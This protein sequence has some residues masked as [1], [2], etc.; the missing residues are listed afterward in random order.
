[1]KDLLVSI[2]VITYNQEQYIAETI[3]NIIAQKTSFPIEIIIGDD[4]STDHTR[5]ICIAY[6]E[7]YPDIIRLRLPKKNMGSMLNWLAN[8]KSCQGKYIA[9][10]EGDDYW[11][12][13][14][15]L[16]KQVDFLEANP[17]FALCSHV[18]DVLD[19]GY[20]RKGQVP[21]KD[22]FN[23]EDIILQNWGIMTASIIFRKEAFQIPDWYHT[24]K[25]GDY[26]LQL[27]VSLKGKIKILPDSMSVYRRHEGGISNTL[28]P[29]SQAAWIVYL[30]YN[31]NLYTNRK[32]QK[33]I[34]EKIKI[35]YK[36]QLAFARDY[37][38][39]KATVKLSFFQI[40]RPFCP[41]L[42]KNFRK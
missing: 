13:P 24:I 42:I 37:N 16:Q 9:L 3:D 14:Y 40:L 31:F 32:Y 22:E 34:N 8:I 12:D 25:N 39:R 2:S 4:C 10:C 23:I 36:V 7:K 11:T 41:F 20:E 30:L 5:S 28:Q 35:I 19:H 17:D 27:L 15:K 38:L 26:G 21:N 18:S 33:I 1:M 29:F 6:K